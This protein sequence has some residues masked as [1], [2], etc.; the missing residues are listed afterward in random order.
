MRVRTIIP[1]VLFLALCAGMVWLSPSATR[2]FQSAAL[3]AASPFLKAGSSTE[4]WAR[5]FREET[6]K[7]AD[8]ERENDQLRR[9]LQ[10][11]RLYSKDRKQ[12]YEE[13]Q[14]LAE[15]LEYRERSPFDLLPAQV[16][17]RERATWWN[18]VVLD[19][20]YEHRIAVGAAVIA[21]DGLVGRVLTVAP[22][23]CVVLLL[24]DE[25]CQVAARTTGSLDVRGVV[26]GVRGN[27]A[28]AALLHMGPLVLGTRVEGGRTIYT[29]GGGGVFPTN[30]P[31]GSVERVEDRDFFSEAVVKPSVDF[32]RIDQVFIV[33]SDH[34]K[35]G[36]KP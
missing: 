14:R 21:A 7:S 25:N 28:T 15:A 17:L 11:M 30:I 36:G 18:T 5:E 34:N 26:S 35:K 6:K 22:Q 20:G 13:N 12:V 10:L 2:R 24:T 3:A 9:E 33:I 8:L 1:I 23:T 31:V 27:A 19:R 16:I 32:S 29:T 4:K